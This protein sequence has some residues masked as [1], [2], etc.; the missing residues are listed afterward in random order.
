ML[1]KFEDTILEESSEPKNDSTKTQIFKR[2]IKIR[3]ND[4][5]FSLEEGKLSLWLLV[6]GQ[7]PELTRTKNVI[8]C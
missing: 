8:C 1:T 4:D 5:E 6:W 7:R 2:G 3:K